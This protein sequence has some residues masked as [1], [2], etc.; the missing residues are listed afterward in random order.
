MSIENLRTEVRLLCYVTVRYISDSEAKDYHLSINSPANTMRNNEVNILDSISE[1]EKIMAEAHELGHIYVEKKGLVSIEPRGGEPYDYL[2]LELNNALSHK[3]VIGLLSQEF[4]I[5]S[6]THINLR[7]ESIRTVEKNIKDFQN[8]IEILH[9]IGLKLYDIITT[10][11]HLS[12]EVERLVSLNCKV[13]ESYSAASRYF[14]T[15]SPSTP[16]EDQEEAIRSFLS[17]LG[18]ERQLYF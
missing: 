18:Y 4:S 6:E 17:Y 11:P 5:S 15:I 9:G 8:D 1:D 12:S 16:R 13:Y 2:L 3:F 14:E 10:I 7:E